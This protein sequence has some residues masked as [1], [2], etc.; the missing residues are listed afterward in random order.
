MIRLSQKVSPAKK[1][2]GCAP[3]VGRSATT[4]TVQSVS[5]AGV[6]Q[7]DRYAS[8]YSERMLETRSHEVPPEI[9][10][11]SSP[12]RTP[13]KLHHWVIARGGATLDSLCGPQATRRGA[14]AS[15]LRILRG[16]AGGHESSLHAEW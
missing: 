10:P 15:A 3:C 5:T 14:V 12:R 4:R 16:I 8:K 9:T 13:W 2:P 6:S 7:S 11:G 1:L